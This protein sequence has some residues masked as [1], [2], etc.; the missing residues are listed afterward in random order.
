MEVRDGCGPVCRLEEADVITMPG[1]R[2]SG[3][4]SRRL[5]V[6]VVSLGR[7][8]GTTQ[9][10]WLMSRGLAGHADIAVISSAAAEN[11]SRWSEIDCPHL[12]IATFSN[13]LTMLLSFF[14]V[15]RF[16]R[17]RRF[18]REFAPDI[19]YYPHGHAWKPLLDLLLPRSATTVL[20]IHDPE[21]HPGEDSVLHR[22]FDRAN[23]LHVDGYVLLNE[24]QCA[25]FI[26]RFHLATSC[27]TVL[28]H[29]I[30]EDV[31]ESRRTLA[32]V[33]GLD[34]LVPWGGCYALFVGR[35]RQYKG[36]A[37]L[38]AAY[39]SVVAEIEMPLVI[40][41]AGDFSE[42]ESSLL[43]RVPSERV[44]VIDHWLSEVEIASLVG[45]ARFVVLPY[46]SATQSGVIPLASA[47]GV[48]A[49]ASK[50][51]GVAEQVLDGETGL[52][53]PA[54]DVESLAGQ[55]RRAA[56][57]G[58]AEYRRMSSRCREHAEHEWG[59]DHLARRLLAFCA[60]LRASDPSR[61]RGAR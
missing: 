28:P 41:G 34:A 16:A 13:I 1:A 5:R 9:Y 50:I 27:V 42:D 57:M 51:G 24:S 46:L 31:V 45:S 55:L 59:W 33:P 44:A 6:L 49:L 40:A 38:L 17:M 15:T 58:E 53:F 11:R 39:G 4:G 61:A 8:G 3:A 47:F 52:L 12:E 35:I 22:A 18:A 7:R 23:R 29:G 21:R 54:G 56:V 2:S 36:I 10:G 25:A 48:P 60:R 26:D 14:A 20:T 19:V 37:V 32:D 30:L 43:R